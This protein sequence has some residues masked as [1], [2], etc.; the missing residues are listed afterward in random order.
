[1][2][3]TPLSCPL[4]CP[5]CS[6]VSPS[7]VG[8]AYI[9]LPGLFSSTCFCP[10]PAT[11][12]ES[13]TCFCPMHTTAH[14]SDFMPTP[15]PQPAR[16][17]GSARVMGVCMVRCRGSARRSA[18]RYLLYPH[19]VICCIRQYIGVFVCISDCCRFAAVLCVGGDLPAWIFHCRFLGES[20]ISA[21]GRRLLWLC[22]CLPDLETQRCDKLHFLK[23][24]ILCILRLCPRLCP[25]QNAC[26]PTR[27][28]ALGCQ[29]TLMPTPQPT[30]SR[31]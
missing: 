28:P 11:A 24:D 30:N 10:M 16:F 17:L 27:M 13:S 8:P 1:M 23:R 6:D 29:S 4:S 7:Y 18:R 25:R 9:R 19:V 2:I 21:S 26:M 15:I 20:R 14:E 3:S 5:N 12:H 22:C 31:A